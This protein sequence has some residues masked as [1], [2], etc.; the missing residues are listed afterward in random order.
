[1]GEPELEPRS[2]DS[3]EET[4]TILLAQ[5]LL[6]ERRKLM[7]LEFTDVLPA[8]DFTSRSVMCGHLIGSS[9]GSTLL[10]VC[11]WTLLLLQPVNS[12]ISLLREILE[13]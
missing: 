4:S 12:N 5:C 13:S 6:T 10:I 11:T 3:T 8:S 2:V 7:E 1:M 9:Y